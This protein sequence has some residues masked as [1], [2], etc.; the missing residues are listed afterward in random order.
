MN[1]GK[2]TIAPEVLIT[3]ARLTTLSVPGVS[4]L[5]LDPPGVNRLFKRNFQGGIHVEVKDNIV[6]TDIHVILKNDVNVRE[7][8]RTIQQSVSRA[9]SEMVGMA[10][11]GVNVHIEDIDYTRENEA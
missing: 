6:Y 3:I 8:S 5:C 9:I 2:T 1:E 4:R 10:V 11:G 7:V